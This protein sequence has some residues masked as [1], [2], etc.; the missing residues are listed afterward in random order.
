MKK[1]IILLILVFWLISCWNDSFIKKE[2]VKEK[3][4]INF[5]KFEKYYS[6]NTINT[7]SNYI[8]I[9]W[10]DIENFYWFEIEYKKE[11]IK[12]IKWILDLGWYSSIHIW[13]KLNNKEINDFLKLFTKDIWKLLTLLVDNKAITEV[14]LDNLEKTNIKQFE[15]YPV[16]KECG[17][18][19]KIFFTHSMLNKL[20]KSKNIKIFNMDF[21]NIDTNNKDIKL[22]NKWLDTQ[23]S[24]YEKN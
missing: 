13:H 15:I 10:Y 18:W 21:C 23:N 6:K 5:D 22:F 14:F 2:T 4:I 16:W 11:N 20:I 12:D 1:I 9:W 19:K 17:N 24:N 7:D 8:F 3:N